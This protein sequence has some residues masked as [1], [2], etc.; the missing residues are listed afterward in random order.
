LGLE[1]G[2]GRAQLEDLSADSRNGGSVGKGAMTTLP[3]AVVTCTSL[4]FWTTEATRW[5]PF[6]SVCV[7]ASLV[8]AR[9]QWFESTVS[10]RGFKEDDGGDSDAS[11][12]RTPDGLEISEGPS[13]KNEPA[14]LPARVNVPPLLDVTWPAACSCRPETTNGWMRALSPSKY[15]DEPGGASIAAAA[16]APRRQRT[17]LARA[18]RYAR[19]T[20][21]WPSS[22][23]RRNSI[24]TCAR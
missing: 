16:A 14:V 9:V 8:T 5:A 22:N 20:T 17:E 15:T 7:A 1:I 11:D 18:T 4:P 21:T 10:Q 13:P 6:A 3:E 2:L 19:T 12:G 24:A 23:F